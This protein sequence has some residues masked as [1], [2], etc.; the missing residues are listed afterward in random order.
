M[1]KGRKGHNKW[2]W[3]KRGKQDKGSEMFYCFNYK[4]PLTTA[5]NGPE[6]MK[7]T[8]TRNISHLRSELHEEETHQTVSKGS[9]NFNDFMFVE[10]RQG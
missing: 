7:R 9:K 10:V 5:G 1:S 3:F 8:T 6:Q 4:F 2:R